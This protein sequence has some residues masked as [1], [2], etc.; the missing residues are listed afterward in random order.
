MD[1]LPLSV[2]LRKMHIIG[3]TCISSEVL[4]EFMRF[5]FGC[6]AENVGGHTAGRSIK[7]TAE[8]IRAQTLHVYKE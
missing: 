4:E 6:I 8:Q 2:Q 3:R 5:S 1:D 7:F